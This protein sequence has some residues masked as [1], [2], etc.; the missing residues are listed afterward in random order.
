MS[1]YGSHL[2]RDRCLDDLGQF[3]CRFNPF[4]LSC[5]YDV[6]CD[7]FREFILSIIADDPVQIHLIVFI[8]DICRRQGAMRLFAAY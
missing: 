8:N 7:I 4:L 2:H 1:A 5:L 3:S 6:L